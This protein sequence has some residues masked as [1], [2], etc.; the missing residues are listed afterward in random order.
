[1]NN[2]LHDPSRVRPFHIDISD[3]TLEQI[4]NRV[5]SFP[6]SEMPALD[7]WAHGANLAYMRDL[8]RYWIE[9]FD[10]LE[11]ASRQVT[12][13]LQWV[14]LSTGQWQ[15]G[16]TVKAAIQQAAEQMNQIPQK[17]CC[18]VATNQSEILQIHG[19]SR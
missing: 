13:A 1:M 7:G 10:W 12:H 19:Q 2:S 6:W 15:T 8:C 16:D 4:R 18:S 9:E 11:Q 14:D 3:E 5:A 17:S